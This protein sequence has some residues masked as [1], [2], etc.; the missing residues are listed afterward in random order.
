MMVLFSA[1]KTERDAWIISKIP[2]LISLLFLHFECLLT[3]RI[4]FQNPLFPYF[5]NL[6]A[7][8]IAIF[9]KLNVSYEI[10]LIYTGRFKPAL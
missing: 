2:K 6:Q 4:I 7:Y 9:A 1:L 8:S 10:L 3:V 5:Q